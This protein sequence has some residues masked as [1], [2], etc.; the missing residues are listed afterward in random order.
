MLS[1]W[2]DGE[3][4]GE[5]TAEAVHEPQDRRPSPQPI[6][7]CLP[8]PVDARPSAPSPG[9]HGTPVRIAREGAGTGLERSFDPHPRSDL[10]KSGTQTAGRE[11]FKTLGG[12]LSRWDKVAAVFALEASRLFRAR[13]WTGIDCWSCVPSP[14]TLVIDEDGCYDP[15]DFND[16]LCWGLKGTMA[17][18]ELHFL[19]T[20]LQGGK[21]TKPRRESCVSLCPV[22]FR[23]DEQSRIILDPDEEVRGAVAFVFRLFARLVVPLRCAN[24]SPNAAYEF[25][26]RPMRSL[27]GPS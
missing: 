21:L 12:R 26:K 10:G 25:P 23:Y 4:R 18:A 2:L 7:L 20:R 16:G 22:G 1:A 14:K 8:A 9:E 24:A 11:D 3:P 17:Q 27:D 19:R 6:R 5:T 15:A 13:T